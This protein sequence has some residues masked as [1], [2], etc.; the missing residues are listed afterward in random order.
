MQDI[1]FEKINIAQIC[2]QCDMNRKSFYYHFRDKYDLINWIFDTEFLP[3]LCQAEIPDAKRLEQAAQYL[4]EQRNFYVKAL[5]IRGQNSFYDHMRSF[6]R[7]LI[8]QYLSRCFDS[9][10]DFIT[11][12]Y[13]DALFSA[14]I[15]WLDSRDPMSAKEFLSQLRQLSP[16]PVHSYQ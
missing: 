6:L 14:L 15:R 8:L 11:D 2:Q 16:R 13:T 7:D 1:P 10:N 3:L 12:V 9:V 4:L 5:A